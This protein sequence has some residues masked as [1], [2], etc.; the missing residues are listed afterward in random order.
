VCSQ[1]GPDRGAPTNAAR[2]ISFSCSVR[3]TCLDTALQIEPTF[4]LSGDTTVK[5]RRA[6]RSAGVTAETYWP[7]TSAVIATSQNAGA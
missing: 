1:A 5:Q 7:D 6:M 4:G 3:V 2:A